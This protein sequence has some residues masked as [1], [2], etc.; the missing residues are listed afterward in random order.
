MDQLLMERRGQR[1]FRRRN[2]GQWTPLNTTIIYSLESR[3][4]L[5]KITV[6]NKGISLYKITQRY[7][8]QLNQEQ[9]F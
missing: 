1:S 8:T 7:T 6:D 4:G 2:G 5:I 9:L 3:S